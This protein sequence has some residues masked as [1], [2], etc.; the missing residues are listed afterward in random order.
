M[1]SPGNQ[2]CAN[3]ICMLSFHIA[4]RGVTSERSFTSGSC[5][6]VTANLKTCVQSTL[7]HN[8]PYAN[9]VIT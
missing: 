3:C 4:R 9:T 2:H 5:R 7:R 1:A 8:I 6:V